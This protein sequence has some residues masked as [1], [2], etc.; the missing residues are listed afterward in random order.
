ME[1]PGKVLR[2][3][4]TANEYCKKIIRIYSTYKL[5]LLLLLIGIPVIS[6]LNIWSQTMMGSIVDHIA[7]A[8]Q[9]IHLAG[10]YG[11]VMTLLFLA[12]QGY[13]IT[14]QRLSSSH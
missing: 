10:G 12:K 8:E 14:E 1:C 5:S 6:Q 11:A 3:K 9:W 13:A 2:L 7:E 4:G